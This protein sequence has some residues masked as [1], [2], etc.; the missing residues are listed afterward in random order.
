MQGET[1]F[2]APQPDR[3]PYTTEDSD[4]TP[5]AKRTPTY[6]RPSGSA[7]ARTHDP[8]ES[9]AAAKSVTDITEKQRAVYDCLA[10]ATDP[11]SDHG[12]NLTYAANREQYGWPQQSESGLRTRRNELAAQGFIVRDGTVKLPTGRNAATWTINPNRQV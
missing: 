8:I 10:L 3:N 2:D 12:L 9:H 7:V 6:W 1:L 5:P 11:L 4:Y